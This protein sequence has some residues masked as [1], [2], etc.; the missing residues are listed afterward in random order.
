MK[1]RIKNECPVC[2]KGK[3]QM[4]KIYGVLPCEVCEEESERVSTLNNVFEFTS[5]SI[6]ND[7]KER[8]G[9]MLQ[10]YVDGVLSREFI[11]RHG[12]SRLEGVTKKDIKEAKYVYKGRMTRHHR[13][14]DSKL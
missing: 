4:H 11:E 8:A 1:T 2:L 14:P 13:I 6:K 9:S 5:P 10:P 12:T 7:R 3:A